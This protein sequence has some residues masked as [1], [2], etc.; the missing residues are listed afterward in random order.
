MKYLVQIDNNYYFTDN[1]EATIIKKLQRYEIT[2]TKD[3]GKVLVVTTQKRNIYICWIHELK[4]ISIESVRQKLIQQLL[5]SHSYD[6]DKYCV[7]HSYYDKQRHNDIHQKYRQLIVNVQNRGPKY[8]AKLFS[9]HSDK[10]FVSHSNKI[11]Y[12][13][14]QASKSR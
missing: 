1:P 10:I 9:Q 2:K 5:I 12:Y 7:F 4:E 3:Y 8:L 6:F 14:P 13:Q 11:F